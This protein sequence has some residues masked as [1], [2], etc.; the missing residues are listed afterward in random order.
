MSAKTL[1]R[2]FTAMG[3]HSRWMHFAGPQP[4]QVIARAEVTLGV[5]FPPT[6]RTFLETLGA[7]SFGSLEI[8]GI[9][10]DNFD[11]GSVPNGIWCTL[12][13]RRSSELPTPFVIIGSDGE[14]GWICLV[15]NNEVGK[16]APVINYVPGEMPSE[17][18]WLLV[19]RDFGDYLYAMLKEEL[20]AQN[21]GTIKFP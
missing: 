10:G 12:E 8:Y 17:D 14:G 5:T 2:A 3:K 11:T 20:R 16:E 1:Q 13:E 18:D 15:C 4:A 9:I 19:A 6:Y 7:G 21:L